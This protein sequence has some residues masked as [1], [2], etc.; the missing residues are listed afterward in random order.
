MAV[1]AGCRSRTARWSSRDA[2]HLI[3]FFCFLLFSMGESNGSEAFV[4]LWYDESPQRHK[5]TKRDFCKARSQCNQAQQSGEEPIFF[6]KFP[7]ARPRAHARTRA[8][9]RACGRLRREQPTGTGHCG[10]CL[11]SIKAAIPV[12]KIWRA[13]P[14]L[15]RAIRA[16][17]MDFNGTEHV[18]FFTHRGDDEN[19]GDA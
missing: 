15:Y 10:E 9:L 17:R 12:H 1:P 8:C 16:R 18:P 6:C 3:Y 2:G 5:G 19:P 11:D 13:R 4:L 7:G 14:E